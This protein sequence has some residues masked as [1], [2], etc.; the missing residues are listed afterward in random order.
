[1]VRPPRP[2]QKKG[3]PPRRTAD[4]PNNPAARPQRPTPPPTATPT[5]EANHPATPA[6][7]AQQAA[8]RAHPPPARPPRTTAP[9]PTPPEPQTATA[10]PTTSRR[11]KK[12]AVRTGRRS[13]VQ[14]PPDHP[15]AQAPRAHRTTNHNQPHRELNRT[16][17][18]KEPQETPKK[19]KR[20]GEAATP[21]GP[22][23]PDASVLARFFLPRSLG[24]PW[25]SASSIR[26]QQKIKAEVPRSAVRQ[27]EGRSVE[28]RRLFA[29]AAQARS[30]GRPPQGKKKTGYTRRSGLSP[31]RWGGGILPLY[32]WGFLRSFRLVRFG[33]V[34]LVWGVAACAVPALGGWGGG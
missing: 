28:R 1:M 15:P 29:E 3:R 19:E 16:K 34:R 21:T 32:L 26:R 14:P 4:P 20:G 5:P 18:R 11:T 31:G 6:T 25:R 27:G 2:K 24:L 23:E 9:T 33:R 8:P 17:K 30:D 12:Q 22:G 10:A 13:R 7:R